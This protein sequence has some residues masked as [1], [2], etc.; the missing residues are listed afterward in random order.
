MQLSTQTAMP[1]FDNT[2]IRY[3]LIKELYRKHA[4]PDIPLTR[5]FKKHV[6][7]VYPISRATLYKILNTPDEDLRF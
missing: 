5:T 1:T 7:P 3:R 2:K 4:H 6:K